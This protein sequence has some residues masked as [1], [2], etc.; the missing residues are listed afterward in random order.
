[1]VSWMVVGSAL[2]PVDALRKGAEEITGSGGSR[3]LPVP[4]ANDEVRRLAVTLNDMLSRLESANA[5]QRAFVADAAHELRSPL[6]AMRTQLEVAI[7]HPDSADWRSTAADVLTD[8]TRLARLVDD[9]LLLARVDEGKRPPRASPRPPAAPADLVTIVDAVLER[10][11]RDDREVTRVGDPSALTGGDADMLTRIVA[12][13]V[14]NA[15][16]H[17]RA[18]VTVE[19]R[20]EGDA[21]VLTVSDDGPGIPHAER[22]RVFE[23]F[24]R[25]DQARARDDGGSGLGLPIVR[26][27]AEALGGS[28]RL[29]DASPGLRAVVRLPAGTPA[30]TW[31]MGAL[32]VPVLPHERLDDG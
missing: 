23:R 27:L 22:E 12:N 26:S 29:T 11:R 10:P 13:L 17:A 31:C 28:V 14:D 1:V 19:V 18:K 7:H 25:L 3:Q 2:R 32:A 6:A 15:A 21:T 5:R 24:T 20:A 9:L 4:V 30:Q 8:T 16:R